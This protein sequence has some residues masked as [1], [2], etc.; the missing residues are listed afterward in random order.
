MILHPDYRADVCPVD[1]VSV[2][3]QRRYVEPT[4]RAV[5]VELD[6]LVAS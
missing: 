3:V 5:F 2:G 6:N 4:G 1:L